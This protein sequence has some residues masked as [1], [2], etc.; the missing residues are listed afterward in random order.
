MQEN[1]ELGKIK[2]LKKKLDKFDATKNSK[3][4]KL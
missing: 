2:T 3:K 1:Q 4:F